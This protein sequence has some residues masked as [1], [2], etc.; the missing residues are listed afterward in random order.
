MIIIVEH[1]HLELFMG[2]VSVRPTH[3]NS[4]TNEWKQSS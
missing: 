3:N 4:M 2:E 1:D